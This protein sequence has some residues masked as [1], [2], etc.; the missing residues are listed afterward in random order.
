MSATPG[1]IVLRTADLGKEYRL[2]DSPRQRLASLLTGRASYRSQWALR[3]VTF[4]LRRG[5]CMGVVGDNGAGKSTLLKLIAGTLK[6]STGSLAQLG[7][8][9][10]ILELGAGF[11]PEFSG[12]D[13]LFFG[14]SLIGIGQAQMLKLQDSIIEFS[15]LGAAIDRSVKTYS[16]GMTVRLAF[17]L[18]TA[19][20]PDV[21]I[22]DEALAVGDQHFQKKCVERIEAFRGNGCT[23][24]FCSH[25]LYHLRQLCDVALWLDGGKQRLWGPTERVLAGY[26]SHVREQNQKDKAP[27]PPVPGASPAPRAAAVLEPER[28][29]AIVSVDVAKLGAGEPPLLEGPDLKVTVVARMADGEQP[30]M[31]VMLE[32]AHGVGITVAATH[33]DGS[34]P[35]RGPDGLWRATVTFPA[36]PLHSGEYVLSAYLA[37][38]QGLVIYDEWL[39]CTDFGWEF[40]SLVPGLV[41]LPHHWT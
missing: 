39:H 30:T 33:A 35:V 17:A 38:S 13:N 36:L 20:E 5:Q 41:Q 32:Q 25:S 7:R 21:L 24:L 29:G 6:P 10:A 15:E 31:G 11:H 34:A 8:A 1:G 19:V 23:I 37:D 40:P 27:P 3:G 28:R 16:S 12:R 14:G 2:Y 26:E 18:V 4:E 22:V 9:T